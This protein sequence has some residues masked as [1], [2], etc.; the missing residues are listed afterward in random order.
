MKYLFFTG[1]LLLTLPFWL[2]KALG[3]DVSWHFVLTDS[4]KGSVDPGAFVVVRRTDTYQVG[5]VVVFRRDLS[6]S[7]HQTVLHRIVGRVPDGPFLVKGDAVEV[8]EEVKEQAVIGRM[9]FAV[10]GVGLL[11]AAFRRAPLLIGAL[12]MGLVLVSGRPPQGGA[13][14]SQ[15]SNLFAPALLALLLSFPFASIGLVAILGKLPTFVLL[16]SLLGMTRYLETS[17]VHK[18]AWPLA[19]INYFAVVIMSITTVSLPNVI[20]SLRT[21]AQMVL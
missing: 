2:P 19:E 8:V 7:V 11:P 4:M 6:E 14:R 10:P 18:R 21:G 3:G 5:D 17:G 9:A 13:A 15:S 16:S 12:M 20:E 1:L